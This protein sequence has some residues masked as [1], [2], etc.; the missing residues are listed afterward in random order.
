[1]RIVIIQWKNIEIVITS[2][3]YF[4]VT[5][6]RV[7]K[8]TFSVAVCINIHFIVHSKSLGY[9]IFKTFVNLVVEKLF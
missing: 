1:M 2:D 4:Q 9:I 7:D 6:Q 5:F 8:F 3:S